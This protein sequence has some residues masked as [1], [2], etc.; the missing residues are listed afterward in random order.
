MKLIYHRKK[1]LD[2]ALGL[3]LRLTPCRPSDLPADAVGG[4]AVFDNCAK[5]DMTS[6]QHVQEERQHKM[7]EVNNWLWLN[8]YYLRKTDVRF[9]QQGAYSG[10]LVAKKEVPLPHESRL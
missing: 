9:N 8:G 10:L 2:L 6:M 1:T 5:Y 7:L 4:Y 3:G